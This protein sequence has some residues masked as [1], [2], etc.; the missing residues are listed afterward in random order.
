MMSVI[1]WITVRHVTVLCVARDK[2]GSGQ[3]RTAEGEELRSA[4]HT[5]FHNICGYLKQFHT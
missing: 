4:R 5:T 2:K 3:G 1:Y